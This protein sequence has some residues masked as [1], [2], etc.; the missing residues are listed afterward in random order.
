MKER[1]ITRLVW[2]F[3]QDSGVA[4]ERTGRR[5][6]AIEIDPHYCDVIVR[7]LAEVAGLTATL[8]DTGATFDAVARERAPE[9]QQTEA[10]NG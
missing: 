3:A 2:T 7:R 8:E 10:L 9:T 1:G 4:A 6:A 5:G